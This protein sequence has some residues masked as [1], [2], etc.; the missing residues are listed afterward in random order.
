ME[1]AQILAS[2]AILPCAK[3]TCK[4]QLL[5]LAAEQA[6]DVVGIDAH[7][8]FQTLKE[9]EQLGS[10]GLGD[11]IAIP[12]GKLKGLDKVHCILVRLEHGIEFDAVDD[13]PVDLA[14]VL[15][16]PQGSGADHL[17]A[18]SRIARLTRTPGLMDRLRQMQNADEIYEFLT[19]EA[20]E[21]NAA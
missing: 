6:S 11:G 3:V 17:K 5:Q 15:L 14:F 19:R 13:K 16:A 21:T 20:E 4:R 9:R 8:I 2:K 1:I 7:Q 12:H 10:T 18:L